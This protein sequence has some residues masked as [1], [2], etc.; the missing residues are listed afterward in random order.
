MN[1]FDIFNPQTTSV[2]AIL[3]RLAGSYYLYWVIKA[4]VKTFD[5]KTNVQ[6]L[7]RLMLG[8]GITL[9]LSN[10]IPFLTNYSRISDGHSTEFLVS[11]A[12]LSNAASLLIAAIMLHLIYKFKVKE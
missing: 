1:Y 10:I 9:L 6:G 3:M 8:L 2:I 7:K 11:S 5:T 4:Q 12:T